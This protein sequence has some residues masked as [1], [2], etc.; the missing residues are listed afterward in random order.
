MAKWGNEPAVG[1]CGSADQLKLGCWSRVAHEGG[2]LSDGLHHG[3]QDHASD[4]EGEEKA[5]GTRVRQCLLT[6]SAQRHPSKI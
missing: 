5:Q 3:I 1:I 2:E 4:H 6:R